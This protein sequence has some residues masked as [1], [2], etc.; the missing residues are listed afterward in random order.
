MT[1]KEFRVS[2]EGHSRYFAVIQLEATI[3][4]R[5][6]RDWLTDTRSRQTAHRIE[7]NVSAK[8]ATSFNL[9]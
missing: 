5:E 7:Q 3:V 6:D 9:I 2:R 1:K 4:K 8:C